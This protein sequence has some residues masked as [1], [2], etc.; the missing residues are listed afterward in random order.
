MFRRVLGAA[1]L[2]LAIFHGWLFAGQAWDGQL[3]EPAVVLRWL[4]AGGLVWGLFALRRQG[5]PLFRGRKA[6]TI[7]LLAAILHGP[8]V[9]E[10]L[11]TPGAPAL[12]EVVAVLTQVSV[13]AA[14]VFSLLLLAALM[15][16]ASRPTA[17][18]I[19]RERS[20]P[21]FAGPLAPGTHRLFAPRPPPVA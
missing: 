7:W 14:A 21:A 1:G 13:A 16:R 8:A 19:S 3:L 20:T 18:V 6:I 5:A 15:G 10:R 17:V 11:E 4:V 9:A 2:L 12:P